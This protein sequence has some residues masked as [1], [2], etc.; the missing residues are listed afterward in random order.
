MIT[1]LEQEIWIAQFAERLMEMQP[2][3]PPN[4]AR[5][6]GQDCW[7]YLGMLRPVD[8][9]KTMLHWAN[10]ERKAGGKPLD[11]A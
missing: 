11:E 2:R 3:F 7:P 1:V 8:G 5:S 4:L 6:I 10:D 9:V